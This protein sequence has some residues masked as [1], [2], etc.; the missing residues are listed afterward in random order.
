[1]R[2]SRRCDV[3]TIL[4]DALLLPPAS[5]ARDHCSVGLVDAESYLGALSQ[6]ERRQEAAPAALAPPMPGTD[7]TVAPALRTT[8][9]RKLR[10]A[11]ARLIRRGNSDR[12]DSDVAAV[13]AALAARR[14]ATPLGPVPAAVTHALAG[15]D[16]RTAGVTAGGLSYGGGERDLRFRP[17]LLPARQVATADGGAGDTG[18]PAAPRAAPPVTAEAVGD[19][20]GFLRP[21]GVQGDGISPGKVGGSRTTTAAGPPGPAVTASASM[22]PAP[23]QS[24]LSLPLLQPALPLQSGAA[25]TTP[26]SE[27][28]SHRSRTSSPRRAA[29]AIAAERWQRLESG[30]TADRGAKATTQPTKR[31]GLA[32]TAPAR[33][34]VI[35]VESANAADTTTSDAYS[36]GGSVIVTSGPSPS[37]PRQPP[38]GDRRVRGG[39]ALSADVL[40]ALRGPAAARR[41][42]RASS[43][44]DTGVDDGAPAAAAIIR[45]RQVS[46]PTVPS[47]LLPAAISPAVERDNA[48]VASGSNRAVT[49]KPPRRPLSIM[50][51][52]KARLSVSRVSA[53]A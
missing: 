29:A 34:T 33:P 9:G 28:A 22:V 11:V 52:M 8:L 21:G 39:S 45:Q 18:V 25:A 31:G 43:V 40:G 48:A 4:V 27:M 10:R 50:E 13:R 23:L 16:E 35:T 36:G 47:A 1:V 26:V 6:L 20:V 24:P 46:E 51:E 30:G 41:L 37:P 3:R 32:G 12:D 44:G 38:A 5:W 19:A 53:A 17:Q 14:R 7:V 2:E 15:G 42:K 49:Q